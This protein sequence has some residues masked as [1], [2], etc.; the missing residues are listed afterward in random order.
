VVGEVGQTSQICEFLYVSK[1]DFEKVQTLIIQGLE[2]GAALIAGGPGRPEG[3]SRGYLV[4]PKVFAGVRNERTIA[5]EEIRASRIMSTCSYNESIENCQPGITNATRVHYGGIGP[6][7]G[8]VRLYGSDGASFTGKDEESGERFSLS[9]KQSQLVESNPDRLCCRNPLPD[10][11]S[12]PIRRS[13]EVGGKCFPFSSRHWG[14]VFWSVQR[15]LK[16][17]S[18]YSVRLWSLGK[19]S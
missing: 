19:A 11:F 3:I 13:Y 7:A 18:F 6:G 10:A 5:G 4:K 2:E 17:T 8:H 15:F 16:R 1:A 12:I 9:G 14:K